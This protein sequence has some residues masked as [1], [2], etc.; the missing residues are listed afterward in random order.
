[1]D[2]D[3]TL[4]VVGRAHSHGLKV[5]AEQEEELTCGSQGR[6]H[7]KISVPL[8]VNCA[9]EFSIFNLPLLSHHN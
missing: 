6:P 3:C 5:E 7:L 4:D 1:M 8:I 9:L 2:L